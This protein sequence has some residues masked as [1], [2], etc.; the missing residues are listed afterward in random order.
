MT[1]DTVGGVWTYAMELCRAL[2]S[3][4][5]EI[6][7]ATMGAPLRR[8]QRAE[9]GLL[10]NVKVFESD[11]KLEWMDDPWDDVDNAGEWLLQLEDQF[12]PDIVHLNSFSHGALPWRV[13]KIVV[14]HSCV[15]SWWRATKGADAPPEWNEYRMRVL[16]GLLLADLVVA[17]SKAML[18]ALDHY[19]GP[20]ASSKMIPN[21]RRVSRNCQGS[22]ENF[23]LGAGRLWDEAKN[24]ATLVK[25][26]PKISW[27]VYLAGENCHPHGHA[28]GHSE[29]HQLGQLASQELQA[30]FERAAIFAAPAKYEPFGLS[31]LEAALA[32]CAMVLGDIPSLREN[33]D[34]AALFVP[35]DDSGA[36]ESALQELIA[37]P[38]LRGELSAKARDI[39]RRL[40]PE[41]MAENYVITYSDVLARFHGVV[42]GTGVLPL[43]EKEPGQG[44]LWKG[45]S[46]AS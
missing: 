18:E 45:T 28:A 37:S 35:P 23:V 40:T 17:P 9:A 29:V 44:A 4:G 36:L 27:P 41:K 2:G 43:V 38:S 20:F 25:C 21:G 8:S 31:I 34:G 22:K 14:G 39:A 12:E 24:V 6:G 13:P 7:L 30:C 33:W 42:R 10:W 5:F 3:N 19:Y 1:A 46:C 26:A 32:D 15:L 16:E 11:Y